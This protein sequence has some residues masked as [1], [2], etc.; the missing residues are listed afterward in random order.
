MSASST[1]KYRR[2]LTEYVVQNKQIRYLLTFKRTGKPTGNV[3]FFL[4]HLRFQLRQQSLTLA[5]NGKRD[6]VEVVAG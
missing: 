1:A 4:L 5:T 6:I 3:L 2:T